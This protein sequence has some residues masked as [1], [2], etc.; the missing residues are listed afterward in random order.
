VSA[1]P[2][3]ATPERI[4]LDAA[5]QVIETSRTALLHMEFC[6]ICKERT[7]GHMWWD[8]GECAEFTRL[9]DADAE[10]CERLTQAEAALEP[11]P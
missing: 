5:R 3:L 8:D 4:A 11:Q 10:A 9:I 1:Q 6:A 2:F 7:V